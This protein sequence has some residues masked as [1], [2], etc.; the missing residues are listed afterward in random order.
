M[1]AHGGRLSEALSMQTR[2]GRLLLFV[3]NRDASLNTWS[4]SEKWSPSDIYNV[5]FCCRCRAATINNPAKTSHDRLC[6]L[7]NGERRSMTTFVG[8]IL[9]PTHLG[10]ASVSLDTEGG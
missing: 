10:G 2:E 7:Q 5:L 9:E 3:L 6:K 8:E 1:G 4:S